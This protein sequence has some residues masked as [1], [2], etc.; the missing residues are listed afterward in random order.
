MKKKFIERLKE[1]LHRFE[2]ENG[3]KP[4]LS[5]REAIIEPLAIFSTFAFGPKALDKLEKL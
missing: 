1:D 4:R 5:T 3:I 2:K